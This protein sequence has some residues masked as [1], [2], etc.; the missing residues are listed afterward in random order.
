MPGHGAYPTSRWRAGEVIVDDY[1]LAL[2]ADMPRGEYEIEVGM[3]TV[4]TGA[5]V[6]V[7]D[8]NGAPMENDRVLF[9]GI[10]L[11]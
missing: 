3:Y 10:T 11:P 2:P 6:R 4:K 5:R 8:V 9:E 7:M 1:R